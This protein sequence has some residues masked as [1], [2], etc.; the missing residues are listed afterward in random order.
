MRCGARERKGSVAS[1]TRIALCL[2]YKFLLSPFGVTLELTTIWLDLTLLAMIKADFDGP[3][4][5]SEPMT[6]QIH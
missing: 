2:V 5:I 6:H 1:E 4:T 3:F